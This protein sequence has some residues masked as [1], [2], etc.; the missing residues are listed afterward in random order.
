MVVLSLV[1]RSS[2]VWFFARR[3]RIVESRDETGG[4]LSITKGEFGLIFGSEDTGGVDLNASND[5]ERLD[6]GQD[7]GGLLENVSM[8]IAKNERRGRRETVA[9]S[10]HRR[11]HRS[12]SVER[13]GRRD[14]EGSRTFVTNAGRRRPYIGLRPLRNFRRRHPRASLTAIRAVEKPYTHQ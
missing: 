9:S 11:M 14:L 1:K 5:S 4:L 7:V 10:E 12:V 8:E 13:Q 2:R 6:E 3:G